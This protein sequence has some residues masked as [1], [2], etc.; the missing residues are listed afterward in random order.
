MNLLIFFLVLIGSMTPSL[1][2]ADKAWCCECTGNCGDFGTGSSLKPSCEKSPSAT[3]NIYRLGPCAE[4][5]E[6]QVKLSV[7]DKA[8]TA[9]CL[10]RF[11]SRG[12]GLPHAQ[13]RRKCLEGCSKTYPYADCKCKDVSTYD[14]SS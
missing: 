7:V 10:K 4:Y 9:D 8:C 14:Y 1:I 11:S 5:A 12:G 2:M 3:H 13:A 6:R